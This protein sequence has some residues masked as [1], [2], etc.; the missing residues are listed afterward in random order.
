[1]TPRSADVRAQRALADGASASEPGGDGCGAQ[2]HG[3]DVRQVEVEVH[4]EADEWHRALLAE[5]RDG[6][7]AEQPTTPPMWF[8]DDSGSDLFDEIT[9]LPEYYPTRCE[10][11]ILEARAGEIAERCKPEM[12]LELGSGTSEKTRILIDAFRAQGELDRFVPFDCSAATLT[13]AARAVATAWPGLRVTAIVGDFRHHLGELP[14]GG[15]RVLAFLG[16]TV[17]NLDPAE[18][19]RFYFD[20]DATLEPGDHFLLGA[21]LRKDPT[22]LVAAYDDAAGVTAAFDRNL[23]AVLN[24]E[25]DADF[26]LDGWRHEAVWDEVNSWIEMRLVSGR[27]QTVRVPRLGLERTFPAGSW[28]RTEIS[29]KFRP[30]QIDAELHEAGLEVVEQWTD[31]GGDFMLTLATPRC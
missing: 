22:R 30:E 27:D 31:P 24:R 18:R 23:L 28:I 12:L 10:K 6:L 26:A 20:V 13:D 25:L 4:L 5:T 29:T 15:R 11:A 19:A 2:P 8:Y 3:S 17:G 14:R 1:V 16:S 9:R 7:L 21:D